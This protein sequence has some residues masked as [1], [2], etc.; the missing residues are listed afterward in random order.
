MS[1]SR[2]QSPDWLR[3]FQVPAHS[4]LTVSSDPEHFPSDSSSENDTVDSDKLPIGE[5]LQLSNKQTTQDIAVDEG[6]V[7][8]SKKISN[9]KSSTKRPGKGDKAVGKATLQESADKQARYSSI[10]AISSD[11]ESCPEDED[12]TYQGETSQSKVSQS[13]AKVKGEGCFPDTTGDSPPKKTYRRKMLKEVAKSEDIEEKTDILERKVSGDE[14][15]IADDEMENP[16]KP[17]VSSSR[18][19]LVLSEKVQRTKA[20]IECEGDSIDLSGDM[21]AVGRLIEAIMSDFIQL[22]PQSDFN[23]AETV[24]EGTL[25]G[26]LLDLDDEADG[27]PKPISNQNVEDDGTSEK[28]NGKTKRKANK[29]SVLPQKRGRKGGSKKAE[30]PVKVSKK[31]TRISKKATTKK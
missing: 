1:S 21:G 7:E 13:Q 17:H 30:A 16:Q 27:M 8:S 12:V 31:N 25:E 11:S 14:V 29:T 3:S 20:L 5:F 6:A 4:A 22:N 2:E 18:L 9:A 10:Y 19:P 23:E 26:F 15:D 24:V 28:P